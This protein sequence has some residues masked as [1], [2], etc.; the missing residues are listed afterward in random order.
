[1]RGYEREVGSSQATVTSASTMFRPSK[2]GGDTSLISRPAEPAAGPRWR[3]DG[4]TAQWDPVHVQVQ[5]LISFPFLDPCSW[6]VYL[7]EGSSWDMALSSAVILPLCPSPPRPFSV[8]R[9]CTV[10]KTLASWMRCLSLEHLDHVLQLRLYQSSEIKSQ[11]LA[12]HWIQ[13]YFDSHSTVI[14]ANKK[15]YIYMIKTR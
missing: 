12:Q 3:V 14:Y 13:R 5:R 8:L 2:G 1:M 6:W 9:G 15:R 11:K 7:C 10:L 4:V